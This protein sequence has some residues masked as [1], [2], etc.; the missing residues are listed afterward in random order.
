MKNDLKYFD[1]HEFASPDIAG[2]GEEMKM[3]FLR[4]LD[5]ARKI[6]GVSFVI[7]SGF[8]SELWNDKVG[9]VANSSHLRGWAADVACNNSTRYQILTALLEVGFNR[10]GIANTFIHVDCDPRKN[11]CRIWTY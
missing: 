3:P 9:G 10:I 5:K 8:R 7:N 11:P 4:K 2:S 1:L 6:A